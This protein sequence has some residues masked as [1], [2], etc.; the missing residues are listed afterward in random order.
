VSSVATLCV[1]SNWT[2]S[3]W[4]PLFVSAPMIA[5]APL[6]RTCTSNTAMPTAPVASVTC[7]LTV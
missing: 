4:G 6:P 1:P 7:N 5:M 2:V 3:G